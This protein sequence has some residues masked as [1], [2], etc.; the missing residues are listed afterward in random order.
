MPKLGL[1]YVSVAYRLL[2]SG[3]ASAEGEA[4]VAA[5]VS[6]VCFFFDLRGGIASGQNNTTSWVRSQSVGV[7]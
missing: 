2:C 4:A 7:I 5:K 3:L 1:S 6:R